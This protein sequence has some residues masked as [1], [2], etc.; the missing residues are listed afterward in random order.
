MKKLLLLL[1]IIGCG[2]PPQ[3]EVVAISGAVARAKYASYICD[4]GKYSEGG[5][6]PSCEQLAR[7]ALPDSI[8]YIIHYPNEETEKQYEKVVGTPYYIVR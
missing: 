4:L 6:T 7:E 2:E 1:F 3:P 8:Y 5:I